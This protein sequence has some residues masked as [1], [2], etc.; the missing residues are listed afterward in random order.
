MSIPE[1]IVSVLKY[2]YSSIVTVQSLDGGH[3][4][5]VRMCSI[6]LGLGA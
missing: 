5:D 2:K 3:L 1:G 6:T 4:D